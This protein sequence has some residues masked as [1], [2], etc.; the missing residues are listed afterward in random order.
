MDLGTYLLIG[1]IVGFL[2]ALLVNYP[3][4]M[5][6]VLA[7]VWPLVVLGWA[8]AEIDKLLEQGARLKKER[9]LAESN[10]LHQEAWNK[11]QSAYPDHLI[12]DEVVEACSPVS[13]IFYDKVLAEI[14]EFVKKAGSNF[15]GFEVLASLAVGEKYS[16]TD[17]ASW[18]LVERFANLPS[19]H[20]AIERAADDLQTELD[21]FLKIADIRILYRVDTQDHTVELFDKA[22]ID[23]FT[24]TSDAC[25]RLKDLEVQSD[26]WLAHLRIAFEDVKQEYEQYLER[27]VLEPP[28]PIPAQKIVRLDDL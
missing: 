12:Y 4:W 7:P 27:Q 13:R 18:A 23:F 17:Y 22:R 10:R 1:L 9:K 14:E 25:A 2:C 11:A 21:E 20:T 5:S 26:E 3:L 8:L 24:T 16:Y 19:P 28:A 6:F 15:R